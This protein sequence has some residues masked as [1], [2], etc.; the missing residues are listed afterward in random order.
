MSQDNP[1]HEISTAAPAPEATKAKKTE[2]VYVDVKLEDGR[3]A[4]FPGKR[5][6][7]KEH[8]YDA[9]TGNVVA[10]FDF[11]NGATRTLVISPTDKLL[12]NYVG[13]GALQKVGDETTTSD[14][15]EDMVLAVEAMIKRLSGGE[16]N[17]RGAG[18][19][20]VSGASIVIQ[21]LVNVTGLTVDQ[22]KANIEKKLADTPDLTRAA[23]YASFKRP[24]TKIGM[25]IARLE[26]EKAR[27]NAKF[28]ADAEL[29]T[30]KA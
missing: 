10:R 22:V 27:K 2:T 1:T 3:D 18:G 23:L 29:A 12:A 8:F 28:D 15:V 25:E 11:V 20:S 14:S 7:Q 24:D 21:A 26:A 5:K 16:W 6:M 17:S 4:K 13:H 19:E 30:W 9:A